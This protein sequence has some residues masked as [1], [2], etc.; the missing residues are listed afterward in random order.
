MKS[1]ERKEHL[2]HNE[3][4]RNA[5]NIDIAT[6]PTPKFYEPTPLTAKFDPRHPQTHA[7]HVTHATHAI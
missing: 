1:Q 2:L 4:E 7:T 6:P 5:K 3:K